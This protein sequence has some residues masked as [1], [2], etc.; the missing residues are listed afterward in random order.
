[1]R[2]SQVPLLL[3]AIYV[4]IAWNLSEFGG[5]HAYDQQRILQLYC[6]GAIAASLLVSATARAAVLERLSAVPARFLAFAGAALAIGFLSAVSADLPIWSLIEWAV[7]IQLSLLALAVAGCRAACPD[8]ADTVLALS[9]TFSAAVYAVSLLLEFYFVLVLGTSDTIELQA[10]HPHFT[11]PRF[12]GQMFSVAIP[13]LIAFSVTGRQLRRV[14]FAA[15]SILLG[16]S[17][18]QGTRGTWLALLIAFAFVAAARPTG[19]RSYLRVA[20]AAVTAGSFVYLIS[21]RWL[22]ALF[23]KRVVSGLSRGQSVDALTN[24]SSR[25]ML[26]EPA[27]R[28]AADSPWLGIGPMNFAAT[29]NVYGNHPHSALL[30]MLSE[31]G[32][33]ATVLCTIVVG[34]LVWSFTRASQE[35]VAGSNDNLPVLRCGILAALIAA[36][37]QSMVDG[38]LVVPTSQVML[39]L[40]FGWAGGLLQARRPMETK[41]SSRAGPL[42]LF[43]AIATA[44]PLFAIAVQSSR[45]PEELCAHYC[46]HLLPRFWVA[47]GIGP[48]DFPVRPTACR[49]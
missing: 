5:L 41:P 1:V 23:D 37:A 17:L 31:W 39:F 14:S 3:V 47:G 42:L 19:V 46:G 27:A 18:S 9:L 40:L 24:D 16:F 15:A 2:A 48:D 4:L 11:N 43:A 33:P 49:P 6:F 7:L 35:P 20:V 29:S 36:L 26:W 45:A 28:Y 30:Q 8:S 38:L 13:L 32:I 10:I 21:A 25:L 44:A 12:A 34:A 22:P